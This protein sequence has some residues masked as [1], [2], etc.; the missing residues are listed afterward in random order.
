MKASKRPAILFVTFRS[1]EGAER[2]IR[3]SKSGFG[4]LQSFNP[5]ILQ[6]K[7]DK[8]LSIVHLAPNICR[9]PS[10]DEILW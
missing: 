3:A 4:L 1:M 9:A 7:V 8:K 2:A 5:K 6:P 10:P